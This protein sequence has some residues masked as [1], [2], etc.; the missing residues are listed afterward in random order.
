MAG[1]YQS[2][3]LGQT[4]IPIIN[5]L[6][7]IFS[8]VSAQMGLSQDPDAAIPSFHLSLFSREIFRGN[9]ILNSM[10]RADKP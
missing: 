8:Q 6:Q 9:L 4:I 5:K 3:T 7:D 2:E 10:L 1:H